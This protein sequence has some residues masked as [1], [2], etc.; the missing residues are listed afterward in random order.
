MWG[1]RDGNLNI[2]IISKKAADI[3]SVLKSEKKRDKRVS[4]SGG[5]IGD[6]S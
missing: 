6:V 5:N 2:I 3:L 1:K 4:C